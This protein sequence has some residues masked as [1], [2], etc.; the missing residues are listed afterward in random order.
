MFLQEAGVFLQLSGNE[1]IR[2]SLQPITESSGSG[3]VLTPQD[4]PTFQSH[5]HVEAFLE[6]AEGA[7]LPLG[8]VDFTLLVLGTR[9]ALVV[10]HRPLEEALEGEQNRCQVQTGCSV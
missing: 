9:V 5:P 6:A 4:G 1:T 3:S 8:L 7:P 10:L 2:E